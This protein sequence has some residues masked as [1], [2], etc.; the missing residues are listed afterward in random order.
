MRRIAISATLLLFAVAPAALAQ[1]TTPEVS[2]SPSAK[3]SGAG[4][5]GTPGTESGPAAKSD[6]VGSSSTP[7]QVNP[8]VRQQDPS[9]IQGMPGNKSGPP[10]KQPSRQ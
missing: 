6:T 8:T 10:A 3:S 7:N 9:N 5:P 1:T 2:T 4:I